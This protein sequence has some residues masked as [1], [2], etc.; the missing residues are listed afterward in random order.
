MMQSLRRAAEFAGALFLAPILLF[1]SAVWLLGVDIFWVLTGRRR[2]PVNRMPEASAAS[3]VIPN[4]N[5]RDL[6]EMYLPSVV[7]AMAGNPANE[8]IVVDNGSTDGSPEFLRWHFPQVTVLPLAENRGFGGGSNAGFRA[9]RNDIVVLLNSD[10]RVDAGFLAPLLAGFTSP[11]VFAVACQIYLSDPAKRREETGLTEGWWEHGKL[12]VSHREDAR[13]DTPFPCFYAGGGSSAFD[14]AKFLDLG[15]FDELLAPF[16]LEDTDLGFLAWKRGWKVLYQPA[17]VVFHEHRGTIGRKFSHSYVNAVLKKNYLLFAWKNIH[18]FPR[19]LGS[20]LSAWRGALAASIAGDLPLRANLAGIWRAFLQTPGAARSRWRARQLAQITDTEAFARPRG[21]HF[22]DRFGRPRDAGKPMR[23]LFVSPYPVLP[24]MHGGAVFMYEALRELS[25]RCEVHALILLDETSQAEANRQLE[26]IC[27]SVEV[28]RRPNNSSFASPS[29]HAVDEF[30]S[31]DVRWLIDRMAYQHRVDIIQIEYTPM[32]QYIEPY[33]RLVTA[34]FEHDVYF[35]SVARTA[36]Y[37]DR[38]ARLKARVEYLRALRYEL[39][40]LSRCDLVQVCTDQNRDYLLQFSPAMATRV[41]SG[42]RACIDARSYTYPGGPRRPF[43]LLF[44]GSSRHAPN[45]IA[46]EWFVGKVFPYVIAACP[47]A[48]LSLV[49]FDPLAHPNLALHP[50]IEVTGPVE[51]V[52][53][54]LA[55]FALFICPILSGSGVRVKLLE[56]FAAGIPVVSTTVGA[57]GLASPGNPVCALADDPLDFARKVVE[58][59]ND[60]EPALALAARARAE[61]E[62]NWDSAAVIARL[63]RSYREALEHRSA[64][65]RAQLADS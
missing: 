1:V 55:S 9:A 33:R 26:R 30:A 36:H 2:P 65:G 46:V 16:Y 15:G 10:M 49:G 31:R 19:F 18:E 3:V 63:E 48:H 7:E 62:R 14:R 64:G 43:S 8:I 57:E 27:A 58:L 29:P 41:H 12:L 53:D 35:Q 50:Q 5:G 47:R 4:W 13:V 23:V 17:S 34:L 38:L 54:L 44:V 56:A 24:T 61:V 20:F 59:L 6:L 40:L 22:H 51:N 60:P 28:M 25:K 42:Q 52:K 11:E 39:N 32:G 45:R 21:S 37:L